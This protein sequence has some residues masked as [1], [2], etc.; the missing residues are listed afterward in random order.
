MSGQVREPMS[1]AR[2][3]V[4]HAGT[5]GLGALLTGVLI[6]QGVEPSL[7]IGGVTLLGGTL[8]VLGAWARERRAAGDGR[9]L[10]ALLAQAG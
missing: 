6:Q 8:G 1:P 2:N 10:V 3:G 7:A 9:L 4:G 5:G